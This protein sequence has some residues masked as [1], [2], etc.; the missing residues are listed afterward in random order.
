VKSQEWIFTR[1]VLLMREPRTL[2]RFSRKTFRE[3]GVHVAEQLERLGMLSLAS[4]QAR[5]ANRRAEFKHL[6]MLPPGDGQRGLETFFRLPRDVRRETIRVHP[7]HELA[8]QTPQ[9]CGAELLIRVGNGRQRF[10]DREESI[11]RASELS[12]GLPFQGEEKGPHHSCSSLF[13]RGNPA[14]ELSERVFPIP[15]LPSIRA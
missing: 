6:G 8:P 4:P 3:P 1:D 7:Q 5:E 13:P 9:L 2:Q 10:L 14:L 12:T 15:A 11:R